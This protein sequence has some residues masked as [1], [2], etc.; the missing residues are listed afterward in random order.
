[1]PNLSRRFLLV[2]AGV[3]GLSLAACNQGGG[4]AGA[5]AQGDMTLGD[6]NAKVKIVEYASVTC[7]HCATF[8]NEV[9]P[10]FKAKYVDTGKV[11]YTLRELLTAPE[12]ISAAGFL[13]ARCAGK[14]KYFEVVDA[15]F[16]NQQDIVLGGDPRGSLMR[17]A[18]TAGL[19][20]ADFNKC[21][22]DQGARDALAKRVEQASAA[23]VA[24]T[25]TFFINGAKREGALAMAD[26]D[27]AIAEASK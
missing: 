16:R 9:F 15:I 1:M 4:G 12:P 26:L 10:A 24:S 17:I 19:S 21:V 14:D 20:E 22:E 18:Q 2:L 13:V 11:H 6:P 23:G 8:N 7:S 25:P 27:A 3:A 5:A